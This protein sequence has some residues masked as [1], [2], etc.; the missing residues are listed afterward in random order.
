MSI[1]QS[2]ACSF[3]NPADGTVVQFNRIHQDSDFRITGSDEEDAA[4]S[5]VFQGEEAILELVVYADD[6][7]KLDQIRAWQEAETPV[8]FMALGSSSSIIWDESRPLTIEEPVSM[9]PLSRSTASIRMMA[10]DVQLPI[11]TGENLLHGAVIVQGFNSG[12][13]D[14]NS[15][16]LA[17]GYDAVA[18]DF[19]FSGGVQTFDG[20]SATRSF[21]LE[22]PFPISGLMLTLSFEVQSV[23]ASQS[24]QTR[25]FSKDYADTTLLLSQLGD[26]TTAEK[27]V[28]TFST[29]SD[30][31]NIQFDIINA[32]ASDSGVSFND[33]MLSVGT[34]QTY[35]AG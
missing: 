25:A 28:L 3:Y 10:T 2:L 29:L 15:N 17:D 13:A 5:G 12:W 14:T 33:V 11:W 35:V 4:G 1:S 20:A 21:T 19:S 16:G 8:R 6:Q 22:R 18:A 31:Y 27:R 9:S 24:S 30:I 34:N 7:A 32:P 26:I 23:G